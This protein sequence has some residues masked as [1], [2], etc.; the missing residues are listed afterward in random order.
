MNKKINTNVN[1]NSKLQHGKVGDAHG[2]QNQNQRRPVQVLS[3]GTLAAAMN[4]SE[5]HQLWSLRFLRLSCL[6]PV[7]GHD[8]LF[9]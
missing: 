2:W 9:P 8:N 7:F 5:I 4:E 6:T 3:S 1:V